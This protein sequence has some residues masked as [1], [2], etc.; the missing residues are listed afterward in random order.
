MAEYQE[1]KSEKMWLWKYPKVQKEIVM[2]HIK[3]L[4]K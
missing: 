2:V 1:K 4:K 3:K